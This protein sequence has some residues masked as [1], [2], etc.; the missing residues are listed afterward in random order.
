[1]VE[2]AVADRVVSGRAAEGTCRR[3]LVGFA[4]RR[5]RTPGAAGSE[6]SLKNLA[7]VRG[8]TALP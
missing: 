6:A 2:R 5:E 8:E 1:M 3:G 7:A 4:G